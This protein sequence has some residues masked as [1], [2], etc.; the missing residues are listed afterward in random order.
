MISSLLGR[1]VI[2]APSASSSSLIRGEHPHAKRATIRYQT[3][4]WLLLLLAFALLCRLYAL[5]TPSILWRQTQ[6]L[7][8]ARNFAEDIRD[9]QFPNLFR[10]EVDWRAVTDFTDTGVVGGTECPFV[11]WLTSFFYVVLGEAPWAGRIV[12]IF[13]SLLGLLFFHRLMHRLFGL[14]M[15]ALST[16][17]L[18]ISPMFVF[19]GRCQM[20]EPFAFAMTFAALLSYDRWLCTRTP[21]AFALAVLC[22]V[23]MLLGKPMMGF[24]ALP[25]AFL[26]FHRLGR[27]AFLAPA[28][29]AFAALVALPVIL[30]IW[31]S[32]SHLLEASGLS[33]AQPGLLHYP[34]LLESRFYLL[35][36]GRVFFFTLGPPLAL[37][38]LAGLVR[39]VRFALGWFPHS[40]LLGVVPFFFLMPGGNYHNDYYQMALAPPACILAARFLL[41]WLKRHRHDAPAWGAMALLTAITLAFAALLNYQGKTGVSARDCGRW[42]DANL[43]KEARVLTSSQAPIALYHANRTGWICWRE[44]YGRGIPF[45]W[46]TIETTRELGAYAIAVPDAWAFDNAFDPGYPRYREVRD[47]LYDTFL[48]YH[49]RT[50]AVFYTQRPADLALPRDGIVLFGTDESWKYLRGAWSPGTSENLRRPHAVMGPEAQA[51]I[52]FHAGQPPGPIELTLAAPEAGREI[53]A[54]IG[55]AAPTHLAIDQAWEPCTITLPRPGQSS[56][57]GE[58]EIHINALLKNGAGHGLCLL[59]MRL[60]SLK[61]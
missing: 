55:G 53:E 35:L 6:T 25:M 38:A 59:E 48:C 44:H 8:V 24:H 54:G 50:F 58:Y 57:D 42:L 61:N 20:P 3:F 33:F 36:A 2:G 7:M 4:W 46:E 31:Y 27:R 37:L 45:N 12:P 13:F 5:N 32:N 21:R 34:F 16:F 40:W 10:P 23:L 18:S 28:L 43:P 60:L 11:P 19:Y 52:R 15:A 39:P 22:S 41:P 1:F 49:A 56:E 30:F 29:Y 17:L 14:S 26:T 47:R 51:R 9:G